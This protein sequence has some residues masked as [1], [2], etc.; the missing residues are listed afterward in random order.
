MIYRFLSIRFSVFPASRV[1][2]RWVQ[3]VLVSLL[4]VSC[5]SGPPE[6]SELV[7][8]YP[9][10]PL[11][12]DPARCTTELDQVLCSLLYSG[13]VRR[14]GDGTIEPELVLPPECPPDVDTEVWEQWGD[15]RRFGGISGLI[16]TFRIHPDARFGNGREVF[17]Q[18]I[19][20]S[21]ERLLHPATHSTNDWVVHPIL[22]ALDFAG[23]KRDEAEH[24]LPDPIALETIHG[25]EEIDAKTFRLRL[26]EPYAPFLDYLA[27]PGARILP[28]TETAEVIGP[29]TDPFALAALGSG[30]WEIVQEESVHPEREIVLRAKPDHWSGDRVGTRRLRFKIVDDPAQAERLFLNVSGTLSATQVPALLVPPVEE[31]PKWLNEPTYRDRIIAAPRPTTTLVAFN[32]RKPLFQNVHRRRAIAQAFDIERIVDV[33]GRH[34]VTPARGLAPE[35]LLGTGGFE[36]A[37][38]VD[39]EARKTYASSD[40]PSLS[41]V[42]PVG[43]SFE[44]TAEQIKRDLTRI[45]VSV[46]VKPL[47]RTEFDSA[48]QK[49]EFDLA[50]VTLSPEAPTPAA[51]LASFMLTETIPGGLNFSHYANPHFH[52][53]AAEACT[54]PDEE[55]RNN[56]YRQAD[57][58]LQRDCAGIFLWHDLDVRVR[59]IWL[60]GYRYSPVPSAALWNAM[61]RETD[62]TRYERPEPEPVQRPVKAADDLSVSKALVLGFVQGLTEF[63]PISS[64]GHLKIAERLYDLEGGSRYL[65]FDCLLHLGTLFAV[66]IFYRRDLLPLLEALA[67]S[68]Q[69][70]IAQARTKT[71]LPDRVA[72]VLFLAVGTLVTAGFALVFQ[73]ELEALF[74]SMG[75]VGMALVATGFLLLSTRFFRRSEDRELAYSS[76]ALIGLAQGLAI[77]PGLSRS[78][79]TIAVALLLGLS[80]ETS[81]RFSFLLSIPAIAGATFLQALDITRRVALLPAVAGVAASL[82]SGLIFLWFLIMIV[83]SGRLYLFAFYTIPLG[84]LV[85]FLLE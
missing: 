14:L 68:P 47:D 38:V 49:G 43:S 46:V 17:V 5:V 20:F 32:F 60:S 36:A 1:P 51:L 35:S 23:A 29:A 81:V 71:P 63:L 59:Q 15:A 52:Y 54:T 73:D 75:A 22:G 67:D 25:I 83:R 65:F 13:L 21:F 18:D 9:P 72:F 85:L 4:V 10:G 64:S 39:Q 84:I 62:E 26:T 66:L 61:F 80:R 50:L 82:L 53:L 78:G 79:T 33:F 27:M 12:L 76:A 57:R 69:A 28:A 42:A 24:R 58:L 45:G 56:L 8:A 41:L 6:D 3:V 11:T 70:L 30:P 31:R 40:W 55:E 74:D 37:A 7:F 44:R 77:V 2:L 19:R 34:R 16:F 48:L